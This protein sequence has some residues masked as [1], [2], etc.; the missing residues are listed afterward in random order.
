MGLKIYHLVVALGTPLT[1]V[2]LFLFRSGEAAP[3]VAKIA[4]LLWMP[5]LGVAVVLAALKGGTASPGA[6]LWGFIVTGVAEGAG[7]A[8]GRAIEADSV[9]MAWIAAMGVLV[10]YYAFGLRWLTLRR[11]AGR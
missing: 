5:V 9:T 10:G 3:Y 2:L 1:A 6:A 8:I 11:A 7:I 4:I